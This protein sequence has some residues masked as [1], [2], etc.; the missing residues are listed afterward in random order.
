MYSAE[1]GSPRRSWWRR[2]FLRSRRRRAGRAARLRPDEGEGAAR[3]GAVRRQAQADAELHL[4]GEPGD[5]PRDQR[6]RRAQRQHRRRLARARRAAR[7]EAEAALER[8]HPSRQGGEGRPLR[9]PGRR[10]GSH[11]ASRRRSACMATSSPSTGRTATRGPIGDFGAPRNGGRVHEGFDITGACG[12][13]LLVARGGKVPRSATTPPVRQLRP[14]Q[15]PQDDEQ[16]FYAHLI[17]PS[18]LRKGEHV[19]TG[20]RPRPH[21]PDRQRRRHPCH[22]HFELRRHGTPVDPEPHLRDWD[23]Y[24]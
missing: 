16:Y 19:L 24:S 6:S 18:P 10:A 22:L 14:D 15:R 17:A 20:H 7:Q 8:S 9:V 5:R 11:S 1:S 23:A 12:T 21:R 3:R 4:Q 2:H 13:P